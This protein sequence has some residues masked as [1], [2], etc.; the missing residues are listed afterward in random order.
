M[1]DKA[2][3]LID[4]AGAAVGIEASEKARH[5]IG[6]IHAAGRNRKKETVPLEAVPVVTAKDIQKVVA[7]WTDKPVES[8]H[9]T[10]RIK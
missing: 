6:L 9:L 1:P 10:K 4:E 5:A 3:D 2:I 7:E 8:I